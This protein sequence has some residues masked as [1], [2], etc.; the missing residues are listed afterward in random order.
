MARPSDAVLKI[1]WLLGTAVC[2]FT[3]ENLWID[4]W[5]QRRSH[6]KLSSFV[7]EALSGIWFLLLLALIVSVIFL[8]VCQVLLTRDPQISKRPKW[9]TGTLVLASAILSGQWF[10]ATGGAALARR[11]SAASP[12]QKRT[13]VLRWQAS[14]TP[15]VKY[16]V[17]RGPWSGILPDK[18]NDQ[19]IDG[20]TFSDTTALSGQ[21][22]YYAVRA[23]NEKGHLSA[24]S[25]ETSVT[26]P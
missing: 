4:P 25:N 5:A 15:H 16:N 24:A 22:Y 17:Y 20:T 6:H 11:S 18:L 23:V 12:P 19:P 9:L 8:V 26:I 21:T 3:A 14:T 13:V 7:P 2:A 1:A 10:A